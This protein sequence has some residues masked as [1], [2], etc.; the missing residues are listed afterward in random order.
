VPVV[1]MALNSGLFWGRRKW[2]KHPGTITLEVLPPIEP[3]LRR[4]AFME[5]LKDRIEAASARLSIS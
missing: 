5:I 2:I 1:P 4:E 3:G